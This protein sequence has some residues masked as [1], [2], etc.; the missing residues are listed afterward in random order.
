[1][2][3][4]LKSVGAGIRKTFE[5]D[6]EGSIMT[7]VHMHDTVADGYEGFGIKKGW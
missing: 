7:V 2:A 4:A 3:N 1:M 5:I 6:Y